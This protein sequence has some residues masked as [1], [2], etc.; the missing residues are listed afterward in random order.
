[1]SADASAQQPDVAARLGGARA[2]LEQ[3]ADPEEAALPDAKVL[4]R[5][6]ELGYIRD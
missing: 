3:S 5:L 1:M 4:E 6:R 2:A